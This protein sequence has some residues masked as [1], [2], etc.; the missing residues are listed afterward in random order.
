MDKL[1]SVE[2]L[3]EFLGIPVNTLYQW[4]AKGYGPTGRRIGKY[5]RYHPED[6]H[7]W[8][9]NQPPEGTA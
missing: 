9:D 7:A 5:V 3:S 8:V 4:R 6:V 2:D 1:W